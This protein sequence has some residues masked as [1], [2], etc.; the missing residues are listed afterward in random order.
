MFPELFR[1]DVN[2]GRNYFQALTKYQIYAR[3]RGGQE[4]RARAT[5]LFSTRLFDDER[6]N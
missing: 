1:V 4:A 6:K 2:G 3:I 5:S